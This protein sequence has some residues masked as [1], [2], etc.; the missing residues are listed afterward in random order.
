MRV[1]PWPGGVF[2]S[3]MV[4][5]AMIVIMRMVVIMIVTVCVAVEKRKFLVL[6]GVLSTRT[7]LTHMDLLVGPLTLYPST[8]GAA[9]RPVK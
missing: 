1:D 2:R 7:T 3:I 5:V 8:I 9:L 6:A 4:M